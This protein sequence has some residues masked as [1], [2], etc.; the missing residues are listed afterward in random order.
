VLKI[1]ARQLSVNE[2][3]VAFTLTGG[4]LSGIRKT[5]SPTVR[6]T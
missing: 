6:G 4:R 1:R 3:P 5:Q 2:K